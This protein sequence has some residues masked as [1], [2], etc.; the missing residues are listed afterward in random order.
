MNQNNKRQ[1]ALINTINEIVEFIKQN[2]ETE[3]GVFEGLKEAF[4]S[5]G[6][7]EKNQMIELLSDLANDRLKL[8]D[9]VVL[10]DKWLD[11]NIIT[12][13]NR[14]KTSES[15]KTC[16]FGCDRKFGGLISTIKNNDE[17]TLI[18]NAMDCLRKIK[19]ENNSLFELLTIGYRGWYFEK[20]WLDGVDGGNNSLVDNRINTLKKNVEKIEWLYDHLEDN[21][22]KTSL[23]ALISS[24]LTF[25]MEE[26]LKTSM[27]STQNVVMNLDIFPFYKNEV[28]VDCGSFVGDT[29]ADFVNEF[30]RSHRRIY[31]Y[32]I[33][34]PT[35]EIMKNNL[36]GLNNVVY[37][38]KGVSDK[39]G[40]LSLAG[41]DAPFHGNHLVEGD[42]TIRVPI[43]KLDDDINEPITFLKIDVEGLDK[44]AIL[45]AKDH[46]IKYHPKMH[47]D[48]YHKLV[49]V[50]E[51]PLLIHSIDPSY[52][53]YLRL[54][55]SIERRMMF[56][57]TSIYAL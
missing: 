35:V 37:N 8:N 39:Q 25:S 11:I 1:L 20:N 51:V 50:F 16:V 13:S 34:A 47:I 24:W 53:F 15:Y 44:E 3:T 19:E 12:L 7:S 4:L 14:I 41:V 9:F 10:F 54:S 43:V 55:N 56:A 38:I 27:Y 33:S 21:Q 18:S 52:K 49:D 23:N 30:N 6:L 17:E 46:I 45:G 57:T 32:D 22:S 26:A 2:P 29:V 31:T 5:F 40:E 36:R 42:G 28:F 48:T